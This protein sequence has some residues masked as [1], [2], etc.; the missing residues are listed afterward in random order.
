VKL[1]LN[2][3]ELVECEAQGE[4]GEKQDQEGGEGVKDNTDPEVSQEEGKIKEIGEAS[5]T[6]EQGVNGSKK[7]KGSETGEE[8][9]EVQTETEGQ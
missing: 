3:D 2:M 4:V 5:P 6:E 9:G 1:V 8:T 7:H